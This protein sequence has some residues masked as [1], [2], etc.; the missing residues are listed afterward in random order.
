MGHANEK[1]ISKLHRDGLLDSFDFE[2]F[3]T[4]ESCLLGKMVK[5]HFT[6]KGERAKE[7]LGLIH[8]DVCGPFSTSARG[9]YLYFITFTD[10]FSRYGFVYLMRHKFESFENFKEFKS[11]VQ[12]QLGKNI[13]ILRSDRGGEYLSQEFDNH[14]KECGIVSQLTPSGTPQWNCVSE[15]RNR[16]LLDMVRS[17]MS[18]TDLPISF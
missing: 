4:C 14:L 7:L 2:S 9:G 12:N 16:T 15:R 3:D 6:R 5:S 13:K 8:T 10:D 1:H 17:M 18:Q 11:K